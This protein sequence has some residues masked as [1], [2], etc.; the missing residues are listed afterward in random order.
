MPARNVGAGGTTRLRS[1]V[2]LVVGNKARIAD[3]LHA[4]RQR[5]S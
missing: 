2:Y 4:L 1:D 5:I 3:T